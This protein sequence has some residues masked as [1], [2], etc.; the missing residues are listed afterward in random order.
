MRISQQI[1]IFREDRGLSQEEFGKPLG[2][3]RGAVY[4]WEHDKVISYDRIINKIKTIYPDF[5]AAG[6]GTDLHETNKGAE[7]CV[8]KDGYCIYLDPKSGLLTRINVE[9]SELIEVRIGGSWVPD[10]AP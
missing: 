4:N 6:T 7:M 5:D 1:Q 3:T 9:N 8:T 10:K 2:A